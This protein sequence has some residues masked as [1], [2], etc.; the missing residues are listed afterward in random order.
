MPLI[1]GKELKITPAGFGD[2]MALQ[3]AISDALKEN[4]IK[5]DLSGFSFDLDNLS[6]MEVGDIGGII[7]AVLSLT[8]DPALRTWL[9]KCSER[10]LFDNNKVNEDFFEAAG[11]RKYYYPIMVEVLKVNLSPFFG[12]ASSL[13]SNLSGISELFQRSK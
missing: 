1:D 2:V 10:A 9:F 11:N 5:L 8:T 12:L 4:G 6:K 7:E 13:F 3:K